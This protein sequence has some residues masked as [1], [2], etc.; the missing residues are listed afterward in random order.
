MES[1]WHSVPSGPNP[2]EDLF[3]IVETPKGSKNKYEIAKEYGGIILDRVLHSSVVY[4]VDYG[5]VPRTYYT[6]KDPIDALVLISEGTYPGVIVNARPIGIMRMVDGGVKD[7][8][9][10]TVAKGD[11][12]YRKIS[13]LND[14]Q[15]HTLKEIANFFETYKILENKKTEVLG[16]GDKSE[17]ITEIDESMQAYA[18]LFEKKY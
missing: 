10:V 16:W 7:N 18:K 15:E 9:I 12:V 6:D 1:Y 13:S 5:L 8:K 11:P 17:A 2:P 14:L 3:V 4:P